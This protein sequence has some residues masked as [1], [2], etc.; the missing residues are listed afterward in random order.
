MKL[1]F[2]LAGALVASSAVPA[3]AQKFTVVGIPD[4]QNYSESFPEIYYDQT[5]W[6]VDSLSL[7]DIAFV[8]HYGDLVQHA[9]TIAEWLVAD[10]AQATIDATNIPTSVTPGNHD[11][12][13]SGSPGQPYIPQNYQAFFPPSRYEHQP[14]WGGASPSGMSSYQI[15]TGGGQTFLGLSVEVD[16]PLAELAWA[17]GVLDRHR[18]KPVLFTTHRYLQDAEDYTAGVPIVPSGRFPDVWYAV[19]GVYQ[20]NGIQSEDLWNWFLRRNPG[21]FM[22]NCGHFHEEYHQTSTNV[23]GDPVHEVLADYQDDPNGGNGWLRYYEIDIDADRIDAESYSPW[24]DQF[25]T[26]A[27]SKFSL[28]TDFSRY[29]SAFPTRV[30]QE[31]INGYAGTQD[32]WLNEAEPNQSY[33]SASTRVSDDDVENFV[34][35]DSQGHALVR[36][37]GIFGASGVPAG[38][39][40]Q[41]ATLSLELSD[42]IDNPIFDTDFFVHR[43]LVPWSEASTWNSMGNGLQVGPE[44]TAPFAQF[45][46]DNDPNDDFLRRIDV[47]ASVQ[48]WSDGAPNW[49][50]AILPEIVPGNDDGIEIRTSESSIEILRPRL[51]VVYSEPCGPTVYG[52]GASPANTMLLTDSGTPSVGGVVVALTRQVP[53]DVPVF[54]L[55]SLASANLNLL[56]GTVL[57][58]PGQIVAQSAALPIAGGAPWIVHVPNNPNLAGAKLYFQS[59]APDPLQAEGLAFSNGLEVTLCQ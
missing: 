2:P 35:G 19:E 27:E 29:A 18:D 41:S 25:R 17:Q 59:L 50:F 40:I 4:T 20:P 58:D 23:Y 32:T 42:D 37:D 44:L 10:Q 48:A 57:V 21:I 26:A 5:Q 31:G 33:G 1:H 24:L 34:F 49:G 12:T 9:D 8:T 38:A 15:W 3:L 16:T 46:G 13:A 6:V 22:V 54:T 7:L 47:T 56:G 14:W 45:D 51:E 43:V 11:I 52:S 30:F 39:T 36:F 55:L 28:T 53:G